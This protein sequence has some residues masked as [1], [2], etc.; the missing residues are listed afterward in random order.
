MLFATYFVV[1]DVNNVDNKEV[2]GV[3]SIVKS[4]DKYISTGDESYPP[5]NE[6]MSPKNS[7]FQKKKRIEV[8][9]PPIRSTS[10]E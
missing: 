3:P 2:E 10:G 4:R 6:Q 9:R 5:E 8:K 7:E 1:G